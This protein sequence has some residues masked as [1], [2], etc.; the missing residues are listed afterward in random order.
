MLT[1]EQVINYLD[2]TPHPAEGGFFRETYRCDEQISANCLP[3]RYASGRSCS[4]AIY[5]LLTPQTCSRIHRL[6]SDEV[7]HFYLGDPI[8]MINISGDGRCERV[9]MGNQLEDGQV[10]QHTVMRGLW[11]G[12]RLIPGGA[13]ALLG[14]TVAPGFEFA[15]YETGE[16]GQLCELCPDWAGLIT[17]LT[18]P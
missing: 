13:W 15:D 11:Q 1:A 2:L 14:T 10:L 7:F 3:V 4:T 5:Y 12:A 16:R 8:E 9:V 6:S 17:S 18:L